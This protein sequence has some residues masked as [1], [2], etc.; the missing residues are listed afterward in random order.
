M[1]LLKKIKNFIFSKYENEKYKIFIIFGIKITKKKNIVHNISNNV[2]LSGVYNFIDYKFSELKKEILISRALYTKYNNK[3]NVFHNNVDLDVPL[4]SVILLVY[5]LGEKYLRRSLESI[6]NQTLKNIEI[7]IVNDCSPLEEDEKI[8]L[9]Y[10]NKDSRIKYIKHEKNMGVGETRLTGLKAAKGYSVSI[11]DGDDFLS[12]NMYEVAINEMLSNNMEVVCWNFFSFQENKNVIN[13]VSSYVNN[14]PLS[15]F[16][17]EDV[18]ELYCNSPSIFSIYTWNKLIKRDIITK[19]GFD[20]IIPK[21][22]LFQDVNYLFKVFSCA[23]N[24]TCIPVN[25]Y[26]YLDN[27]ADSDMNKNRD[28]DKFYKDIYYIISDLYDFINKEENKKITRLFLNLL[29][30]QYYTSINSGKDDDKYYYLNIYK[31][32]VYKLHKYGAIDIN[33]LITL[34][35]ESSND[36]NLIV[37]L[38][39]ILSIQG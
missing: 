24:V 8:C 22:C 2:D 31:E 30:W 38:E 9:E 29:P 3:N 5:K 18:L 16:Y 11:V 4:V 37:W 14:I 12:L 27:R 28:N 15:S 6:V 1:S 10:K 36:M 21:N 17:N 13:F 34:I 33:Y 35:K 39:S 7:I 23:K 19:L 26:F 25:L 32:S 20:N